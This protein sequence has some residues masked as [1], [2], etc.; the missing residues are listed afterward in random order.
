[1]NNK[2]SKIKSKS[3]IFIILG[4]LLAMHTVLMIYLMCWGFFASLKAE[5][6][7]FNL[8]RGNEI[9][10]PKGFPW[11]WQWSNYS[12]ITK[13]IYVDVYLKGT[14]TRV[15]IGLI[16]ML[17]NT[18]IITFGGAAVSTFVPCLVAYVTTKFDFKFSKFFDTIILLVMI[19][20]IVGAYLSEIQVL[21]TIGLY[22]TWAGFFLQKT[23]CISVYYLVFKAVFKGISMSYSEAA[24]IEGAGE[25]TVMFKIVIPLARTVILTIFLIYF[26]S[27]WNDYNTPLLY[28]TTKPTLAFGIYYIVFKQAENEICNVPMRMAGAFLLFTPILILFSFFRKSIMQNLSMGGVKE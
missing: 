17:F 26:I 25:Y 6:G 16:N 15:R 18:L 19:I 7:S 1:M 2:V 28:L 9:G 4:V 23:H 10:L 5:L 24:Y 14:S 20:P 11:Q 13:Y 27:Y 21:N 12:V 3:I 22:D 8:F